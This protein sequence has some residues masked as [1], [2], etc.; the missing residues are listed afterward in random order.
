MKKYLKKILV[1]DATV[2]E[3][4]TI[5]IDHTIQEAVYLEAHHLSINISANHY[6]FCL[7]PMVY[8][9]WI[10]NKQQLEIDKHNDLRICFY[11]SSEKRKKNIVSIVNVKLVNKIEEADGTLLLLQQETDQIYHAGFLKPLILFYR[12]FNKAG[13]SFQYFKSLISAYSYPR[14]V[15]VIS[16]KEGDYYN[17][18]PMDLLGDIQSANKY[19]FGLRHTN[20]ALKKIM[21]TKKIVVSEFFFSQKEVVYQLSKH[22]GSN[23][24][25]LN[26]LPFKTLLSKQFNFY[27]PEW[28]E[29]YKEITITQTIDLG[30]H[31]LL[32]GEVVNEEKLIPL[33][34]GHLYHIHFLEYLHQKRNGFTYPLV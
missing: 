13:F 23:P 26:S 20:I 27:V 30:S 9:I 11:S 31:M 5:T 28:A 19:A 2:T 1:G 6:V 34:S 22:H 16:F 4:S 14:R 21:E 3:Y 15:R 12:Y 18:F 24:P 7:M 32:W 29:S 10:D 17:I 8:G 25:V 33:S